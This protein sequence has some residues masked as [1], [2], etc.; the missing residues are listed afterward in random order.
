MPQR[1]GPAEAPAII[2]LHIGKTAGSTLRKVL[3]RNVPRDSILLVQTDQRRDTF[4][5]RR[6]GTVEA[7]ANIPKETR[8]R[9]RL[10]EGH[11][12]YGIHRFVPGPSTYITVIRNPVALAISQYR[13]VLR[14]PGHRLHGVVTSEAMSLEDYVRSG[15][16]LEVDN[17]QTR[18][19]AGDLSAPFGGCSEAMLETAKRNIEDRFSVVG[20]TERFDESLVLMGRTFGWRRLW[21]VPV[22]VA[23]KVREPIPQEVLRLLEEQNRFDIALHR[24]A[25]ERFERAI[26]GAA[27]FEDEVRRFRRRNT[28]LQR[29]GRITNAVPRGLHAAIRPGRP[30]PTTKG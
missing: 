6:E 15:V 11:L 19:I 20:L 10:V 24:F 8:A 5:P 4:R 3:H 13:Y 17:S 14:T 27:G 26:A 23:P 1:D 22:K 21:Y 28:A 7:F 12:I 9:A 30:I 16:S 2:F 18:V 25:T 29:L